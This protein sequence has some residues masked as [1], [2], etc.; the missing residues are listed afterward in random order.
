MK[1]VYLFLFFALLFVTGGIA[2]T[3]FNSGNLV[4]YKVG[5]GTDTITNAGIAVT[6]D[7]YATN[8]NYVSS[9]PMPTTLS[10]ANRR[11]IASGSATTEGQITRSVDKHFLLV[12]G[13]DTFPE[14]TRLGIN[15][16]TSANVNRVIGIL[17]A[18]GVADITTAL[19]DD[20]SGSNI[21]G[22]VSTNGTDLWLA[23]TG[24]NSGVRYTT[25][26]ASTSVQL[27]IT[28]NPTNIRTVNIFNG[29]LY[30][31][32]GSGAFKAVD[33]VGS[34]LPTT[35]GQT[36]T[37][38]SGMPNTNVTGPDPYA[39]A[40]KPVTADIIYVS[41]GRSKTN[42]GGVQK[43][44]LAGNS[45]NLSY[46][47][48]SG[49]TTGLR[50]LV[51]DWTTSNPTIYCVNGDSY[52]KDMPGNKI[53]AV[54]DIDSTSEFSILATAAPNFMFRGIAFAPEPA[55]A[56]TTYTFTGNGDWNAP[57]NWTNNQQ[58]PSP[59]PASSSIVIDHAVGGQCILNVAQSLSP[60]SSFTV[61][62]GKNL[63]IQGSLT[64]Q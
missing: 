9:H 5:N 49:L 20:Y 60:G 57:A 35:A 61:S 7:E 32:T 16:S 14:P 52:T 31:T 42:G 17:G 58:P 64:I 19:T 23:G 26:G 63:V 13:Y 8:G 62:A 51:V 6:I 21:R 2:Q 41:D 54:T 59:L 37:V 1:K 24:S 18:D 36:I 29:Q 12:T 47:L 22:A 55:A 34:G 33:S 53:V 40:I 25:K 45:W 28:P 3:A 44:V 46:T 38:L 30:I 4:V 50:N 56:V 39:F 10:G 11:L 43:W 15:N 27:S 48:D